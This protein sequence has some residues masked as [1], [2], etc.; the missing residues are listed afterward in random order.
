[1]HK[2][3]KIFLA[4]AVTALV[5]LTTSGCNFFGKVVPDPTPAV[6]QLNDGTSFVGS[7]ST[8]F[9]DVSTS[10]VPDF[11]TTTTFNLDGNGGLQV[12]T[13][14]MLSG[15]ATCVGSGQY[16]LI[17][18]NNLILYI[19]SV[20]PTTCVMT[21]QIQLSSV[22]VSTG[23][24]SYI[25]PNSGN[26]YHLFSD[27]AQHIAPVGVWDFAGA[28]GIDYL[29]LDVHGYFVMQTTIGGQQYLLQGYYN[30][31]G[32]GLS[33]YYFNNGDPTKVIGSTIFD[34]FVTNGQVLELTQTTTSGNI[35][36]D[37]GIL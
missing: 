11:A 27:R 12:T 32:G 1:M 36:L 29:F 10:N 17:G 7:W 33:L 31:V 16:R 15:G 4:M 35:V 2:H 3:G 5:T 9:S 13:R 23:Y 6:G 14:D 25:D 24:L 34:S 37:G 30:I 8:S 28:G 21:S 20:L 26:A 22:Q 18:E 19:Q